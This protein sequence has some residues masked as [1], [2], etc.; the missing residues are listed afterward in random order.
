MLNSVQKWIYTI[1]M[2][3]SK[4]FQ[5]NRIKIANTIRDIKSILK[6]WKQKIQRQAGCQSPTTLW[7]DV[8][9]CHRADLYQTLMAAGGVELLSNIGGTVII[10]E[11]ACASLCH[12]RRCATIYVNA[13]VVCQ[14]Q[15]DLH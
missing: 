13:D 4:S 11:K 10:S 5:N 12:L 7:N 2:Q 1:E 8:G 9:L 15:G 14:T 3:L 6:I